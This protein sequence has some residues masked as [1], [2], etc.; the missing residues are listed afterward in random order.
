MEGPLFF[1]VASEIVEVLDRINESPKRFILDCSSVP[2][3]DI[4]GAHSLKAIIDHL[5]KKG[6]D[7]IFKNTNE[8]MRIALKQYGVLEHGARIET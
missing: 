5:H 2:L 7:V 3:L 1:G 6:T 4:T 8:Q